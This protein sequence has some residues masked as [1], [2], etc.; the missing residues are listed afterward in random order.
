[1]FAEH[2]A[3]AKEKMSEIFSYEAVSEARDLFFVRGSNVLIE[4]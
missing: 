4:L 2:L 3:Q 1:L